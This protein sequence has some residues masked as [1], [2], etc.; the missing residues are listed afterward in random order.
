MF[1]CGV[2]R[3][4]LCSSALRPAFSTSSKLSAVPFDYEDPLGMDNLL[5][6][7][8]KEI[9]DQV[10]A[11]ATDKLLPR[12]V[13]A[14]LE[15]HFDRN[16][17]NEMGELGLLG[18]NLKG[19]GC[20]GVN[21]VSYGLI[22]RE[23][24]RIDSGYRSAMSVQSSLVM[25]PI[26][27]YGTDEQKNK[28]LP[29]L[30]T[31][32]LVGCFGLTEPN[33]GSD[34]GSMETK[35]V[36]K[37]DT[38]VLNGSKTWITN[39]PIADVAV[40]WAK[41]EGGIIRGFLIERGT[42]GFSTPKI[43]GKMSLRASITGMIVL[44][45]CVIPA[46]N[47]LPG[48]KGLGGPFRCLNS[49]RYGIAWGALGAAESCFHTARQYVLDRKQFHQP[50]ASYQL[51][52]RDLADMAAD[53]SLGLLGC[54][55]VGRL[56]DQGLEAIEMTSIIKRNSCMKA[57]DVSRKARDM[58]GGN[59]ISGEY[60]VISHMTNLETVNTYEGTANI[61]ALIVGRGITGIEAFTR[62]SKTE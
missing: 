52:Q 9:R 47:I 50:L 13:K 17:M 43:E 41:D 58:L 57:L 28:F 51:V 25:Y 35:A 22:A 56:K 34:P 11:F 36:K 21:Y 31:G 7:E 62:S 6:E 16:I 15:E 33:H 46:S 2:S 48:A 60:R 4:R 26:Y 30:A 23:V 61:H 19:Y 8:E 49:A 5:T 53:I 27:T 20:S 14:N 39:S 54:L 1:A 42:P 55:Q 3:V 10:R 12:V 44:E 29:R 45:N 32:E 40:V 24:E 59:G 37:G 18:A 38:Y